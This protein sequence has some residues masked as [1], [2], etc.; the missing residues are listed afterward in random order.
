[1]TERIAP[2]AAWPFPTLVI[3]LFA[4]LVAASACGKKAEDPGK[5]QGSGGQDV[6]KDT[7]IAGSGD[8]VD[9]PSGASLTNARPK[10]VCGAFGKVVKA[11]KID[12][13]KLDELS[14]LAASRIHDDILWTHNDSGEKKPRVYAINSKGQHVATWLLKGVS[15]IDWEDIA[16]GPCAKDGPLK[17]VSCIYV[18]DVGD[19]GHKRKSVMIHRVSEPD[20]SSTRDGDK[21][22]REKFRKSA[23]ETFTFSYP[24]APELAGSAKNEAEHPDVEAMAVLP[25]ARAILLSKRD[26]G[27]ATVFRADLSTNPVTVHRLGTLNL[28]DKTLKQGHSLRATSADLDPSGRFLLVRTYF[29]IYL[30]DLGSALL[31]DPVAARAMLQQAPRQTLEGG[32]DLQGEAIAW[33]ADGGFWHTSEGNHQPLWKVPC[34][35]R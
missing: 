19:N 20:E 1:M 30:F 29:R 3:A 12:N 21:E 34:A 15:P 31:A 35:K 16:T 7:Q 26:D 24:S 6:S 32:L 17:A 9:T 27:L 22:R 33:A 2:R 18:A 5:S 28:R 11:G 8:A 4:A 13:S 25:D 10:Q 14:G 23:T